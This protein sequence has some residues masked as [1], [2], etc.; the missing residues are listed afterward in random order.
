VDRLKYMT[1]LEMN[2]EQYELLIHSLMFTLHIY[3][4]YH[5]TTYR[6]NYKQHAFKQCFWIK[7]NIKCH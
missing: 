3:M 6:W 1:R 2:T 4:V 7:I 5:L